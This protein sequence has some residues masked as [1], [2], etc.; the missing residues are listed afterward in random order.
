MPRLKLHRP[1][2]YALLKLVGVF[3]RLLP[4]DTAYRWSGAMG[5]FAFRHLPKERKKTLAHLAIAFPDLPASRLEKI[6]EEAFANYGHTLAELG[7][8]EKLLPK[9]NKMQVT[10]REHFDAGLA[11]GRGVIAVTAHFANWELL[12]GWLAM[13]GYPGSV[14]ARRIYYEPYDRELVA[15]RAKMRLETIY[16]D[17][18]PRRILRALRDNRVL[19]IVPD[20][21]VDTVEGV[22]VD[23]F[24]RPA[25]TPTAPVRF[26][27]ASGA[28]LVPCF[29]IREEGR[30]RIAIEPPIELVR[31]GDKDKDLVTNTQ[32]WVSLQEEYIRRYPHLWVWNHK[33]WKSI[34]RAQK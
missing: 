29:L 23:F 31:T 25:Y 12:G 32:K 4:F 17:E 6:G 22:F 3:F 19:G 28:P 30:Y 18:S 16:R 2:L 14:V 9:L 21:D 5:R 1:L 20:Q 8:L 27:A 33:R 24:G 10:G 26:A 11:K 7:L 13:S 15:V 34:P